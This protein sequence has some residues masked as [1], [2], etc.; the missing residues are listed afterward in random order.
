MIDAIFLLL[1]FSGHQLN[2]GISWRNRIPN[3]KHFQGF[4]GNIS[5]DNIYLKVSR[6]FRKAEKCNDIHIF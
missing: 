3:T 2:A 6:K 5:Y 4:L 1:V